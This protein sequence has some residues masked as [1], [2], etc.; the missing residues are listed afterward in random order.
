MSAIA[1][2]NTATTASQA[3]L[4]AN[5]FNQQGRLPST[6]AAPLH[7]GAAAGVHKNGFV[8]TPQV[9]QPPPPQQPAASLPA[10]KGTGASVITVGTHETFKWKNGNKA[11]D[12]HLEAK[13]LIVALQGKGLSTAEQFNVPAAYI[14]TATNKSDSV[15]GIQYHALNGQDIIKKQHKDGE[16]S[17]LVLHP[18][19]TKDF[20]HLNDGKG[21][22]I[23][24]NPLDEYGNVNVQMSPGDLLKHAE[25]HKDYIDAAT[26]KPTHYQVEVDLSGFGKFEATQEEKLAPMSPLARVVYANAKADFHAVPGIEAMVGGPLPKPTPQEAAAEKLF[27]TMTVVPDF[28][29]KEKGRFTATIEAPHLQE[30]IDHY[31][32]NVAQKAQP[33]SAQHHAIKV[34]RIGKGKGGFG[35]I[36]NELGVT[37]ADIDRSK[38]SW[39]GVHLTTNYDIQHNGKPFDGEKNT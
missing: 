14:E 39:S 37:P 34:I 12:D 18:N 5:A 8:H 25:T 38:N 23:H 29:G 1:V 3:H 4:S 11:A 30:A 22:K 7:S 16:W 36:S 35:D 15:I 31:A 10:T 17:T 21:L 24:E 28:R 9:Q 6:A 2:P 27:P 32:K 26:G 19:Q 20:S 33:T 13:P